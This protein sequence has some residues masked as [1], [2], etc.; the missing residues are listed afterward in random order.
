[1]MVGILLTLAAL[2]LALAV[3]AWIADRPA[4]KPRYDRRLSADEMAAT[5]ED[6]RDC[7]PE[8]LPKGEA[9]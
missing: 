8:W 6:W 2:C 1:M 7:V 5:G 9:A 4:P 3:V